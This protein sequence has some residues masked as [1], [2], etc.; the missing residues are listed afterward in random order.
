MLKRKLDKLD[1]SPRKN[2]EEKAAYAETLY[3]RGINF[4][5]IFISKN[6]KKL[7]KSAKRI[8]PCCF[9]ATKNTLTANKINTKNPQN[10]SE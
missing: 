3:L 1:I 7:S 6:T 9:P 4:T 8:R 5:T 10:C 2:K